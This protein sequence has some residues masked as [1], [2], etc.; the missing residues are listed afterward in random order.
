[1][2]ALLLV[3]SSALASCVFWDMSDWSTR[4]ED[5]AVP[6]PEP[7]A[8]SV[9]DGAPASKPPLARDTF[10]RTETRGLGTSELGGVWE[11][12]GDPAGF[13][14][15]GQSAR[16]V[17]TAGDTRKA[18]LRAISVLDVESTMTTTVLEAAN[19]NGSY[20]SLQQ[21]ITRTNEFYSL[22]LRVTASGEADLYVRHG[23]DGDIFGQAQNVF[24]AAYT[25]G[26]V[27]RLRLRT[28]GVP[29]RVRGRA[30]FADGAEPTAWN[31]DHTDT[32]P[33]QLRAPGSIGF[34]L[35]VSSLATNGPVTTTTVDDFLAF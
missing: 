24:G 19:G 20:I 7:D 30:W 21:R 35:Y 28:E 4:S 34:N 14:V 6:T 2:R 17:G 15:D 10:G 1:M 11:L 23:P 12:N 13:S 9:P 22:D 26:R 33:T 8:A 5:R 25:S 31:V 27:V 29:P 32:S 3:A 18:I 16:L